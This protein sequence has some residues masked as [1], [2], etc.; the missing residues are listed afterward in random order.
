MPA[1]LLLPGFGVDGFRSF[2]SGDLQTVAPR[3]GVHLIAGP[4]NAGKSNMLTAIDRMLPALRTGRPTAL[5][6]ADIPHGTA[7]GARLPRTAI[8]VPMPDEEVVEKW[9]Q[10]S[11]RSAAFL[12]IFSGATFRRSG[13]DD[14]LW[15]E[16]EQSAASGG[17]WLASPAQIDDVRA[18][19][20]DHN[21][22]MLLR[23]LALELTGSASDAEKVNAASVLDWVTRIL[24]VRERLP[25]VETIGAFRRIADATPGG[26]ASSH[27]GLGLIARLAELQNPPYGADEDRE[28]FG[29]INRFIHT[30]FDDSAA[31]IEIPHDKESVLVVYEGRRLPLSSYG[32]GVHEVVILAAAATVLTGKLVC[33]EEPEIHLHPVL[34]RKLIRYLAEQT[35]NQYLIATHSAHLLDTGTASISTVQLEGGWTVFAD[36]ITP[37]DVAKLSAELGARAS[38]LVQAN[39]VIWVEGP[40]DRTYIRHWISQLAPELIEGI[41]YTVMFYGGSLLRHLSAHDPVV[42]AFVALPRLNRNFA[43][44]IDS[45][46][47]GEGETL[48]KTKQRVMDEVTAATENAQVLITAG[49]TIE[50]YVPPELLELVVKTIHPR[51]RFTATTSQHENPLGLTRFADRSATAD[52][53]TIADAVVKAATPSTA[54]RFDLA[55]SLAPIIEMV[56]RANDLRAESGPPQ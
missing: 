50:N 19:A 27:D 55:R 7:D 38:D 6:A 53:A 15:F 42:D 52:K 56:L 37:G 32:T 47:T 12:Q 25:E 46:L 13:A 17:A 21:A 10:T 51:S 39:A 40:S 35:D 43:V 9:S 29:S 18:V 28:R 26:A 54:W 8:A 45:D 1:N 44:V 22:A 36:A 49:C 23:G 34:Q 14:V 24:Q 20:T 11:G 31:A 3:S 16:F 2:G 33:I 41:H 48:S 4:N 30:L 5:D